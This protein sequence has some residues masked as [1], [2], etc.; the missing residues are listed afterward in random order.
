MVS[1]R[2]VLVTG[3]NG[4]VGSA[5]TK[6]LADRG[7]T[8]YAGARG[9]ALDLDVTDQASVAR[10]AKEVARMQGDQGLYAVVNNAGVIVQ[11]PLELISDAELRR[12]F[13]VNVYGPANIMRVF[14]P[15]LRQGRGR[16]VN[17]SAVSA[18]N[19]VPY[20]AAISASKAALESL[21][22]AARIELAPW[23]VPVVLIQ[24]GATDTQ[25]FAKAAGTS[26]LDIPPD[27][28]ALY[29]EQ[30]KAV[31]HAMAKQRLAPV[32]SLVDVIV[33]AIEAQRPKPRYLAGM[34]TRAASLL[35]H[36]PTRLR[37]RILAGVMG[38]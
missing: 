17:I 36:L 15:L 14:L 10:A 32:K 26:L 38:L 4:G 22:D 34:D 13:E 12:Q 19:A 31:A 6:A 7:F 25:I 11:G 16:I 23:G 35:S 1:M 18:I 20:L 27:R 5:L 37:D 9:G 33:R 30:L 28:L 2:G 24:P 29:G 3:A 8:V 21:S